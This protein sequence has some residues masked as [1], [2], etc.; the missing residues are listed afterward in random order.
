MNETYGGWID[1]I[2]NWNE[3]EKIVE[4]PQHP[5]DLN[6]GMVIP[7]HEL[8]SVVDGYI[9]PLYTSPNQNGILIS[10]Q[11]EPTRKIAGFL[12][13]VPYDDDGIVKKKRK[14]CIIRE[15]RVVLPALIFPPEN[16]WMALGKSE[17]PFGLGR[18]PVKGEMRIFAVLY[19]G[20]ISPTLEELYG[21]RA[22]ICREIRIRRYYIGGTYHWIH[23]AKCYF[24]PKF[25]LGWGWG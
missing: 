22:G 23:Q 4:L 24:N 8:V 21:V 19:V 17:Y 15:G 2:A 7:Q 16:D 10:L 20:L 18:Y 12:I 1:T 25:L 14:L 3:H 11:T 6:A 13:D 5:D 9:R